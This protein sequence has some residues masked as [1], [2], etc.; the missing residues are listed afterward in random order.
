MPP[1]ETVDAGALRLLL[2]PAVRACELPCADGALFYLSL[3][4]GE[5]D[6]RIER[7]LDHARAT[8]GAARSRP[9]AVADMRMLAGDVEPTDALIGCAANGEVAVARGGCCTFP[10]Y[11]HRSGPRIEV[12]TAL[13]IS[14]RPRL[15][16][17]GLVK[18]AAAVNLCSSY[19]PNAWCETPLAAWRRL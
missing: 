13:P 2:R 17:D 9:P 10:L 12:S 6:G 1:L 18:A 16:V 19:E 15:S 4:D 3:Y 14:A 7:L 8:L 11:W 5:L